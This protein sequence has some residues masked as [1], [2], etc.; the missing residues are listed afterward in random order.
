MDFSAW[1]GM[2]NPQDHCK[3]SSVRQSSNTEIVILAGGLSSRM[4]RDK[5]KVRLGGRSL[6]VIIRETARSLGF[7]VRV[8]RRDLIPRRGP[9]GGVYTA[10]RSS[11]AV[12]M[13]FLSCDMPLIP[14][15]MISRVLKSLSVRRA[16]FTTEGGFP[17]FPFAL[18]SDALPVVSRHL[19]EDRLA[20]RDLAMALNARLLRPPGCDVDGLL[21]VNTPEDLKRAREIFRKTAGSKTRSRS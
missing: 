19:D 11:G 16:V 9:L 10:L 18:R 1:Q 3:M 21:N 6:L 13:V 4:G 8:I 2:S 17:G 5:A 12:R 20:L 7:P 14:A 15:G